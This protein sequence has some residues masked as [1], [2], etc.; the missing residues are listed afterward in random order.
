MRAYVEGRLSSQEQHQVE[1]YL[2]NHP[3]E[4]EAME[5]YL[6]NPDALADLRIL[7]AKLQARTTPEQ[8][9][10]TIPLWRKALP[11]AAVFLLLILSSI[12]IINFFQQ[13]ESFAPLAIK[14]EEA[15]KFDQ[16]ES[17]TNPPIALQAEAKEKEADDLPMAQSNDSESEKEK[18][19]PIQTVEDAE[20][21]AQNE[22]IN[23]EEDLI[24]SE[25]V[26]PYEDTI[27]EFNADSMVGKVAGIEAD[28]NKPSVARSKKATALA[29][30]IAPT[31][32][33]TVITSRKKNATPPTISGEVLDAET[34]EAIP[35]ANVMVKGTA[36]ATSTGLDGSFEIAAKPNNVLI[37]NFIGMEQQEFVVSEEAG[38]IIYLN[39]DVAQLS[40]VVVTTSKDE[41]EKDNT[42]SDARPSIGFSEYRDYLKD[43]LRYPPIA[44]EEGTEGK[45]RLKL[46]ISVTGNITEVEVLKSVGDG[47]DEEA[48]RLV[49][50][51]P[52]WEPAKKGDTPIASSKKISVRFKIE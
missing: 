33:E 18:E 15:V 41:T 13:D 39:A 43:N 20:L 11:Y 52:K 46:S 37:V 47:C 12:L 8:E 27:Q 10:R 45:V 22:A 48:I 4:A 25:T 50:E 16:N 3:F 38:N 17:T 29:S 35:E 32:E 28:Q 26:V 51:G 36:I 7:K 2:L 24:V 34:G 30:S 31:D 5:G 6:E 1:K 49:K 23:I 14:S 9:Q 21:L 44:L 42:Y 19:V 40:E